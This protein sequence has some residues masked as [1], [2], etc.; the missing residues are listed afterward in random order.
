MANY[1]FHKFVRDFDP[2]RGVCATIGFFDGVHRGHQYLIEQVK[3]E[4]ARRGLQ[5]IVISFEEH[6]RLAISGSRYW[7]ELLTTNEQ[8]LSLLAHSGVSGCALLHFDYA[9]SL[10]TSREFMD[11]VLRG[12]M[13]VKCL[14]VGYD[15][16]FGSDLSS[17]FKEYVRFGKELGIEL[18]RERPYE[19]S[20]LRISSSATRRFLSGGN[21]EMA[22]ACLGRPYT[23]AGEIVEGRHEG[24]PM[25]YPTANLS[26]ECETQIV[27]GRGVYA[28]TAEIEGFRYMAMVNIG[29]RPTLDNGT[30]QTI[31]SHLLDYDGGNLY[32]KRMTLGFLRRVRDE[33][34]FDT[35]ADLQKQLALDADF[36]RSI[37]QDEKRI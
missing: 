23:L 24:T 10:L 3:A 9:M 2:S 26:P 17:G 32:G 33:R 25:G 5:P 18:V 36:V 35:I 31:E 34:R 19:A 22:R 29:R 13:N 15:H 27:P 28:A 14:V 4:A 21:V 30:D 20:D 37:F 7:P 8:K 16:K 11:V 6:P 1:T 12:E